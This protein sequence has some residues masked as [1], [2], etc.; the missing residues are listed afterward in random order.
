VISSKRFREESLRWVSSTGFLSMVLAAITWPGR[1]SPLPPQIGLDPSWH[2][3]LA[4]A[5]QQ[6]L[7]F[8]T[9]IVF[10]YGPLGFL[11]VPAL[12]YANTA[13]PAFAF[14]FA[15]ATATFA[16]LLSATRR[17][18]P[19]LVA[20][21]VAYVAGFTLIGL[22]PSDEAAVGIAFALCVERLS[23]RSG[24]PKTEWRWIA[25]GVLAGVFAL[26]KLSIG[27]GIAALCAIA[28]WCVPGRRLRAL[29]LTGAPA[30]VVF[31]VGWFAT[32]NGFGN[33]VAYARTS[34]Q[35]ASGY[36]AMA[37]NP[38]EDHHNALVLA[39]VSVVVIALTAVAYA[40]RLAV[41]VDVHKGNLW[42]SLITAPAPAGLLLASAF[43]V[44]LLFKESFVRQDTHRA[45]FFASV[46]L[47][48]A[49]LVFG[50]P[51]R[52][53]GEQREPWL[54]RQNGLNLVAALL[55]F[56]LFGFE[57]LGVIPN[58][59]T[60]PA[61]ALGGFGESVRTLVV[62]SRRH[63]LM[64]EA[65]AQMELAYNI[66]PGM[67]ARM[68]GQTVS[69]QPYE[70]SVAWTYPTMRWDPLPVIQDYGAY[71]HALD[72]I[73][74]RFVESSKAPRFILRQPPV[75]TIDGQLTSWVPPDTQVAIQCNYREVSATA[76]WQLLER[77]G[78]RCGEPNEIGHER[79]RLGEQ[80]HIPDAPR[81]SMVVA[82]FDLHL[83]LWWRLLDRAYKAPLVYVTV[84]DLPYANRLTVETAG[85][86]HTLQPAP[87]LGYWPIY[88]PPT[89]HSMV[90]SC[91]GGDT[92]TSG[93]AVTYYSIPLG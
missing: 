60:D 88:S 85:D 4:M 74:A 79:L 65:R 49:G 47:I 77:R 71:T 25:L 39:A 52:Q 55:I 13:V 84:N 61:G 29:E 8:G 34:F 69:I 37:M 67:V 87:S 58:S 27:L 82:T 33:L 78:N 10:T 5:A 91:S 15:L 41:R 11:N 36:T 92:A 38:V 17:Y 75:F 35:T 81:G 2:A 9:R 56:S 24:D 48:L 14:R 28:I 64:A 6:R 43:T 89:I 62:P 53:D 63:H 57:V 32:G 42:K 59:L 93:I 73:D 12:Y 76:S 22:L 7:P 19:L 45:I 16:V 44:W 31:V 26:E 46:P 51:P 83:S 18:V 72:Q 20:L 21:P 70:Q 86:K 50:S 3:A 80:A 40:H 68:S 90:F 66:P 1:I 23:R 54:V 30:F